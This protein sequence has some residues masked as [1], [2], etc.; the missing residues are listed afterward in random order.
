MFPIGDDN[1][2]ERT[3]PVVTYA[4]IALNVL[5]FL[6]EISQPNIEAFIRQWGTESTRILHGRGL[7]TLI[8]SMFLHGGWMHLIGNMVFLWTFGDNV[9]VA[10][11]H[12]LFLVF[13]FV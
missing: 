7:E 13:Y 6:L 4:L 9:E 2:R 3:V 8:T 10:F 5:I 1:S 11:G 12:G